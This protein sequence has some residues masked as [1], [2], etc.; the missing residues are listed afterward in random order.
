MVFEHSERAEKMVF[1][2]SERVEKMVLKIGPPCERV[3]YLAI[4]VN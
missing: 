2:N 3:E 4:N 1:D